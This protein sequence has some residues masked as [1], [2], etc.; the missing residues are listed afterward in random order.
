MF[1]STAVVAPYVTAPYAS[2]R[3]NSKG[4]DAALTLKGLM[5]QTLT[6]VVPIAAACLFRAS[7]Q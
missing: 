7:D 6:S 4:Q 1:R 2:M 5:C 3:H